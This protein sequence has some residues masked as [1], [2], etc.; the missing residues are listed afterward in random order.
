MI[1]ITIS[2]NYAKILEKIISQNVKFF[3]HWIIV[4]SESD[5]ETINVIKKEN[6]SKIIVL[7]FD[8]KKSA[9]FNKGGGVKLGQE[10]AKKLVEN[11]VD[12]RILI[13]DSDIYLPDNF[14]EL[15]PEKVDIN[16]L[17]G[18]EQRYDYYSMKN[19]IENKPDDEYI[20]KHKKRN[21]CGFFQLYN[22][23]SDY[24]Y[25]DSL[26]CSSCDDKFSAKFIH[27]NIIK[28]LKVHH[29]GVE[30]K[31][32]TGRRNYEDFIF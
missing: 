15:V 27:A 23:E 30:R 10:Y 6:S 4:T 2:V 19:F 29:F 17:F 28:D 13:L 26:S 21:W 18:V 8:F 3:D 9:V 31:H 11:S 32:W 14:P 5:T 25:E 20:T 12:K 1:A 24:F 22:I 7:F 16:Q